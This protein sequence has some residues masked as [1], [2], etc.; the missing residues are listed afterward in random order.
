MRIA[1][2]MLARRL[3]GGEQVFIDLCGAIASR[4]HEV[5]AIGAAESDALDVL[6][7]RS[8]LQCARVQCLGTWDPLCR[9][10][11]GRLLRRF[12]P[13]VV[14]THMGRASALGGSAARSRGY[15]TLAMLHTMIG[16]KYYR[17]IDLFVPTTAD[18]EAYLRKNG[19]SADRVERIPHFRS[20]APV[21]VA[22]APR[23]TD[24]VVKTLGRFVHK[25]GFDVLL[26]AAAHAAAQGVPFRLEIGGDGPER[27]SLKALAKQLG[28]G[29]RV[30]FCGWIDDVAAFLSDAD[31]FVL[32][33]RIEPFG[34]VV[35]E[36]MA[37]GVPIVATRV[38]GPLEILDDHTALL[39]PSDDPVVLAEAVTAAFTAPDAAKMR[40]NAALALFKENYA[41]A[42]VV[43]RYLAACRRLAAGSDFSATRV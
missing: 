20:L 27:N 24:G 13:D 41:E 28:I 26:H 14:Q 6:D 1:Q 35:L 29:D 22:R 4:G 39:V 40:A 16:L 19:V 8:D 21:G 32:P 11:I 3:G 33:S 2:I 37:C 38:S 31:V 12:E 18:Q 23:Q 17:A 42:A 30:T 5:L 7:A 36:A 34:I 10:A 43:E 9:W 15:P 25:K